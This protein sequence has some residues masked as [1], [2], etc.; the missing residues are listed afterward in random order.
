MLKRITSSL[1]RFKAGE[2]GAVTVDW[3]VLSA[4]V[5][6]L[7]MLVLGPIAYNTENMSSN[8]GTYVANAP[9]GYGN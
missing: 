9:V 8:V 4:A 7:G 2:Q 6:G 1:S 5:I 3:V